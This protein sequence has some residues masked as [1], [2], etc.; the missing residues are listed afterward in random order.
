M[1]ADQ[2]TPSRS[3]RSAVPCATFSRAATAAEH[4]G[5]NGEEETQPS[6]VLGARLRWRSQRSERAAALQPDRELSDRRSWADHRNRD[7]V[8]L[9]WDRSALE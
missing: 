4:E 5:E 3:S 7:V 1:R 6:G 2:A 9:L 8:G